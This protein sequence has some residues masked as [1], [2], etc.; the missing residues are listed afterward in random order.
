MRSCVTLSREHSPSAEALARG[1]E[2]S[3]VSYNGLFMF[4]VFFLLT[5]V[6]LHTGLWVLL[7]YYLHV[8]RAAD[9]QPSA[10]PLVKQFARP[11]LQP[12]VSHNSLPHEDLVQM[13]REEN[14]VFR[15]LG[16]NIEEDSQRP[17]I[18]DRLI[19]ELSRQHPA[20]TQ[21]AATQP[22]TQKSRQKEGG[23]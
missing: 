21:P 10:I 23:Q 7:V 3:D 9:R 6:V 18:P 22:A 15:K 11:E 17:I 16:W 20:A 5:A 1:Y 19:T 8:P 2:P 14:Q 4:V 12:S 13:R